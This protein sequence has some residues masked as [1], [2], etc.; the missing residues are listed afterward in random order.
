MPQ[1]GIDMTRTS[2]YFAA[3]C[4]LCGIFCMACGKNAPAAE[5]DP[6]TEKTSAASYESGELVAMARAYY[7]SISGFRAPE[8]ECIANKGGTYTIRLY[9][10]VEDKEE[11]TWHTATSCWYTVD[12]SGK[13]E[14]DITGDPVMLP[15]LS[16]ADTAAYIGTPVKLD[17]RELGEFVREYEITDSEVF[18]SCMEALRGLVIGQETDLRAMD[19]GEIYSFEFQDGSTWTV[20]FDGGNL[21]KNG[22]CYETE[23]YDSLKQQIR[24]YA[25]NCDI[26]E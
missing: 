4:L 2:I 13:G 6:D 10:I 5:T 21:E 20:S 23:G 14:D 7:E 15:P 12:A 1:R 16:L 8:T 9:E 17:Y 25:E 3:A 19:N 18:A 24:Q 26:T 11:N 22:K